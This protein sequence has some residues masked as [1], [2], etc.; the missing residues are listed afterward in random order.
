MSQLLE[1]ILSKENMTLMH[2][3]SDWIERKLKLKVNMT[4]NKSHK[5]GRTEIS[6]IRILERQQGRQMEIKTASGFSFKIQKETETT[7]KTQLVN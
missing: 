1:E 3:I 7:D 6:R 5:T 2:T 4:K